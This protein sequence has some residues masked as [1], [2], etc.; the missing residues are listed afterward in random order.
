MCYKLNL[1]QS[2]DNEI[3]IDSKRKTRFKNVFFKLS[4]QT[5]AWGSFAIKSDKTLVSLLPS[6][7]MHDDNRIYVT[8][9]HEK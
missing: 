2:S 7:L 5:V 6:Q 1:T 8:T 4:H 3:C 9:Q